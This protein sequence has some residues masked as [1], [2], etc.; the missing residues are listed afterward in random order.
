M[1][2]EHDKDQ[3]TYFQK[4]ERNPAKLGKNNS[5]KTQQETTMSATTTATSLTK[6]NLRKYRVLLLAMMMLKMSDEAKCIIILSVS[7]L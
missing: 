4:K 2:A 7:L 6:S 5:P 1:Q 3:A